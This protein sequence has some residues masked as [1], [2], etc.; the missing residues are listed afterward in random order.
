[1][2]TSISEQINKILNP[3]G[4]KITRFKGPRHEIAKYRVLD[5]ITLDKMISNQKYEYKWIT[6]V[7]FT[8]PWVCF[9]RH[10]NKI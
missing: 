4:P 5:H 9:H 8:L 1:V 6:V 7:P 2:Q 3:F 10:G